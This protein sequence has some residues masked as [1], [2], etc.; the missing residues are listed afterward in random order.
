MPLDGTL[1]LK[2]DMIRQQNLEAVALTHKASMRGLE[3]AWANVG[4]DCLKPHLV[5][6]T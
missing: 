6:D 4:L 1:M 2:A 3:I 5:G